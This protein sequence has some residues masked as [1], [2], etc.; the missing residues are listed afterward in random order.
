MNRGLGNMARPYLEELEAMLATDL[1]EE[2]GFDF[3]DF[4]DKLMEI[5]RG[6]MEIPDSITRRK[7]LRLLSQ[8]KEEYDAL[9]NISGTKTVVNWEDPVTELET[10]KHKNNTV[11]QY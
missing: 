6:L 5:E 7:A 2:E 4:D 3:N 9:G 8:V 1:T 11:Y 10:K